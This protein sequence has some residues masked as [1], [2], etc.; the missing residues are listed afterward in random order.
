MVDLSFT[1]SEQWKAEREKLWNPIENDLK[2][3]FRKKE[4]KDLKHYF[5]SGDCNLK[6][7]IGD[8]GRFIYFPLQSE[9][10][11]DYVLSNVVKDGASFKSIMMNCYRDYSYEPHRAPYELAMWDYFITSKK[12]EPKIQSR[13]PVGRQGNIVQV[14]LDPIKVFSLIGSSMNFFLDEGDCGDWPKWL[15]REEYYWSLWPYITDECFIALDLDNGNSRPP[16]RSA[17]FISKLFR[18]VIDYSPKVE[19]SDPNQT[20]PKFLALLAEK[21]DEMYDDL[22][23]RLQQLW[24]ETK[25][26]KAAKEAGQ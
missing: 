21:M 10:G 22:C 19:F 6:Y 13:V 26:K 16:G 17:Y 20:R 14:D 18:N 15:H 25:A 1:E 5:F 4:L 7:D 2:S 12:F 8:G 3:D 9:D 11:W 24:D 23:P